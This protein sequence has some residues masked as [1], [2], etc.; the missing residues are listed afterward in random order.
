M[1][2]VKSHSTKQAADLK[3]LP[4]SVKKKNKYFF[5]TSAHTKTTQNPIQ[6]EKSV[7]KTSK[8]F[9]RL[10]T[11]PDE[12]SSNWKMLS[13]QIKPVPSKGRLIYLEKK[14][15]EAQLAEKLAAEQKVKVISQKE[16]TVNTEIE[17]WF[18]DV[19]PILLDAQTKSNDNEVQKINTE[20]N[21]Q[22]KE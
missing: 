9:A 6:K 7:V 10:P 2:P 11:K 18:D 21:G 3:Q 12:A 8:N 20:I 5:K 13:E 17:V 15:K 16:S 4:I 14:K 1:P 19:D 22:S